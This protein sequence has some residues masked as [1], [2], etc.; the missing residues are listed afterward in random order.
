MAFSSQPRTSPTGSGRLESETTPDLVI[1]SRAPHESARSWVYRLLLHNIVHLV[2][3]PGSDLVE[4]E[5]RRRLGIS[6]TPIREAFMQLAQENFINIVPQKGTYVSRI[7]MSQVLEFRYIR[8]C[9]E[10]ETTR[11]AVNNMTQA[12]ERALRKYITVQQRAAGR[13]DIEAFIRADDDMHGVIYEMAGKARV[14]EF[15]NKTNLQHMRSR[16]LRLRAGR[17]LGRLI[18]EH[19]AIVAALAAGD[20]SK[21]EEGVKQHLSDATWN[22]GS[23]REMFP[24]Y[25]IPPTQQ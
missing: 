23:V 13:K 18:D 16:I 1:L 21:A 11:L 14:W 10:A 15:F 7:D 9:V 17:A 3:P 12:R 25:I 24:D 22:A 4:S 5:V 8:R 2:L 20:A 19:K 6:R